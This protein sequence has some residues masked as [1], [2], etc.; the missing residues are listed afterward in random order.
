MRQYIK[1]TD[2][3]KR[4]FDIILWSI[5]LFAIIL[6]IGVGILFSKT[7]INIWY[8]V[9]VGFLFGLILSLIT[10]KKIKDYS[11]QKLK[12]YI[13]F[14]V[15]VFGMLL[16]YLL[17]W[18]NYNFP[19]HENKTYDSRIIEYAMSNRRNSSVL[20]IEFEGIVKDIHMPIEDYKLLK[21]KGFVTITVD[22]GLL[23]C[24]IILEKKIE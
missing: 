20:T 9:I 21:E 13:T 2:K 15:L 16:N 17:L 7:F 11:S 24:Y 8:L 1:T 18:I 23:G 6:F 5:S 10:Y 4:K 19:R 14:C 12:N 22:K 3:Q